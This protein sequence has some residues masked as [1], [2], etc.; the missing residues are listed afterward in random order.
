MDLSTNDPPM[1]RH[2]LL[3]AICTSLVGG[4]ALIALGIGLQNDLFRSGRAPVWVCCGIALFFWVYLGFAA[5]K[6]PGAGRIVT[7][8]LMALGWTALFL[9]AGASAEELKRSGPPKRESSWT[10][11]DEDD[12]RK[13]SSLP[14]PDETSR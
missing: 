5:I 11:R 2:F 4:M 1:V 9:L 6:F 14:P 10:S 8:G 13:A 12:L 7:G 3:I